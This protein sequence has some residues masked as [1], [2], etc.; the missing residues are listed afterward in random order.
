MIDV[1]RTNLILTFV[2]AWI[3]ISIKL[4]FLFLCRQEEEDSDFYESVE[5]FDESD[6]ESKDSTFVEKT[7]NELSFDIEK[8]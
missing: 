5:H 4:F 2:P 7:S 6:Q 3:A 8:M 1:K